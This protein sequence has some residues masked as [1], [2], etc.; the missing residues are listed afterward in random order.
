MKAWKRQFVRGWK[1]DHTYNSKNLGQSFLGRQL[2]FLYVLQF[3]LKKHKLAFRFAVKKK[4]E[5]ISQ[6]CFGILN[7]LQS[8]KQFARIA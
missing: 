5:M 1:S 7:K 8:L 6:V 2:P 4:E 3:A